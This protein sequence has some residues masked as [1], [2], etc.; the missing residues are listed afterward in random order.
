MPSRT[1]PMS[2]DY[3]YSSLPT[4]FDAIVAAARQNDRR[5]LR[6]A[7]TIEVSS[8]S[9][10]GFKLWTRRVPNIGGIDTHTAGVSYAT[11]GYLLARQ[12]EFEAANFL[13]NNGAN[14]NYIALG[15][16]AGGHHAAVAL[17]Q[18]QHRVDINYIARGYARGGR[19]ASVELCLASGA[20][21]EAIARGYHEGVYPEHEATY[22][23]LAQRNNNLPARQVEAPNPPKT[24]LDKL[25]DSISGN[26]QA[27]KSLAIYV[28]SFEKEPIIFIDNYD[29]PDKF[30]CPITQQLPKIPVMLYGKGPFDLEALLKCNGK[31]PLQQDV[32][33]EIRDIA[34]AWDIKEMLMKIAQPQNNTAV[35]SPVTHLKQL[36]INNEQTNADNQNQPPASPRLRI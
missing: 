16:A 15:Y 36:N 3:R 20:D 9:V 1:L 29:Y 14:V 13:L 31:D 5:A 24:D 2:D 18:M 27:Q 12:G 32:Q 30:N 11:P 33:F 6:R 28:R 7:I 17:C 23:A 21:P 4:S 26:T 35:R 19:H 8:V 22:R 34:P 25:V 10:F